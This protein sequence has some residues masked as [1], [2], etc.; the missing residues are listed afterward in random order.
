MDIYKTLAPA[1]LEIYEKN[2]EYIEANPDYKF[3][4]P[5]GEIILSDDT[6][7]VLEEAKITEVTEVKEVVRLEENTIPSLIKDKEIETKV[8]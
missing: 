2:R 8:I 6:N 1:Y 4:N 7:E 5:K 3:V